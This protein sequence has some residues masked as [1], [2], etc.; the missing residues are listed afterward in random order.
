MQI[1]LNL[2]KTKLISYIDDAIR[3]AL[4]AIKGNISDF[5][6]ITDTGD[7]TII[8]S[9]HSWLKI[10]TKELTDVIED[11]LNGVVRDAPATQARQ[12][13][14]YE[15]MS[16]LSPE[17][18]IQDY[19]DINK[20]YKEFKTSNEVTSAP[21]LTENIDI[22][23]VSQDNVSHT[24]IV[25]KIAKKFHN[26]SSVQYI[27]ADIIAKDT[28]LP[29][30]NIVLIK[31]VNKTSPTCLNADS[32]GAGVCWFLYNSDNDLLVRHPDLDSILF[33]AGLAP[34]LYIVND[35]ANYR[36]TQETANFHLGPN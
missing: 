19:S 4:E 22:C 33:I 25:L 27:I 21:N 6:Q 7:E 15:G 26:N 36:V 9:R 24:P 23:V 31:I 13:Q 3:E 30:K 12:T 14:S 34:E 8:S 5:T 28:M 35:I 2:N 17:R 18:Q 16:P 11:H 1:T 32:E 10:D 20:L 29:C